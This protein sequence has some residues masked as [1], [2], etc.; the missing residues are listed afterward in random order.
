MP[1]HSKDPWLSGQMESPRLRRAHQTFFGSAALSAMR[2][3]WFARGGRASEATGSTTRTRMTWAELCASPAHLGRWVALEDVRYQDGALQD[4]ELLDVDVD[5]AA[6]C[7]RVQSADGSTC[8]I[9]F[10]EPTPP[11]GQR[12]VVS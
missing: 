12:R 9:V 3:R 11:R 4:G 6:L 8:A 2:E 7:G 1:R 10:C 5:L